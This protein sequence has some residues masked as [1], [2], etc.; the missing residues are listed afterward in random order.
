MSLPFWIALLAIGIIVGGIVLYY[1]IEKR[2]KHAPSATPSHVAQMG[3]GRDR[4]EREYAL[5][6]GILRRLE[7]Q[8]KYQNPVPERLQKEIAEAKAK[9]AEAEQAIKKA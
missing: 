8:A 2:G 7:I 3:Y 1:L 5:W 6:Q 4:W 9:I